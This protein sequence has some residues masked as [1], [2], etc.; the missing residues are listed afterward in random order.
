MAVCPPELSGWAGRILETLPSGSTTTGNIVS[1]FQYNL[2]RLNAAI[3]TDFSLS[4]EC[5]V[6]DLSL[7]Q[8]GIYEQIYLCTYYQKQVIANLGSAGYAVVE[9]EGHDQGRVRFASRTTIAQGYRLEAT[10]CSES[11]QALIDFYNQG[12]FGNTIGMVL[13]DNRGPNSC[14]LPAL[15]NCVPCW[16]Y[17]GCHNSVFGLYYL[18][19]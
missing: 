19:S 1:F 10:A 5:I 13:Y 2:F 11:L 3:Y 9:A 18:N 15:A 12:Q 4:G 17:L 8:S 14:P 16:D 7:M 6:P